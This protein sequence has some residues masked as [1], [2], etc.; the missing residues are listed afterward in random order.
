MNLIGAMNKAARISRIVENKPPP[1]MKLVSAIKR[2]KAARIPEKQRNRTR[3]DEDFF[4]MKMNS[5]HKGLEYMFI[6]SLTV[7][8][9]KKIEKTE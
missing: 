9:F 4:F 1:A 7:S 3:P 2:M 5:F 6:I 8:Y